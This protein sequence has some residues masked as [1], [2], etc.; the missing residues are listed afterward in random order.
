MRKVKINS[1]WLTE[2]EEQKL[3]QNV[4]RNVAIIFQRQKSRRSILTILDKRILNKPTAIRT[5]EE[6][7]KLAEVFQ[8]LNCFKNL[9]PVSLIEYF[10]NI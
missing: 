4:K 6:R 1:F 2:L 3:G 10:R 8:K 5:K 7:E 9:P